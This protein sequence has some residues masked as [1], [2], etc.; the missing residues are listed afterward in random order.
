MSTPSSS[1][2]QR[3]LANDW[4]I[5]PAGDFVLGGALSFLTAPVGPDDPWDRSFDFTDVVLVGVHTHYSVKGRV[6]LSAATSLLPKK[7]EWANENPWQ[8]SS[9]GLR[10]GFGKRYAA[11]LRGAVGP[12]MGENGTWGAGTLGFQGRKA[13]HET[14]VF[15]GSVGGLGTHLWLDEPKEKAWLAEVGAVG[16]MIFRTPHNEVAVWF[17]TQFWFPVASDPSAIIDP[18]TRVS[19]HMGLVLAYVDKWDIVFETIF[20]DR[21]DVEEPGSTLPILEGGFDQTQLVFSISRRFAR[22]EYDRDKSRE[23]HI[24]R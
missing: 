5:P 13:I 3:T 9:G 8:G 11:W 2:S 14:I 22:G 21:G 12:V 20:N 18:E 4:M 10:V 16:E 23:I 15:Q 24:A 7:P 6:E 1:G 17:G 19:F